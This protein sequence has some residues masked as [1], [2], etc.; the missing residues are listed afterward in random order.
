MRGLHVCAPRFHWSPGRKRR[1]IRR[2]TRAGRE[3][4]DPTIMQVC[5]ILVADARG[6]HWYDDQAAIRAGAPRDGFVYV[7]AT[8]TPGFPQIR[9][10]A[11]AA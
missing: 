10:P 4:E 1:P 3:R 6:A 2:A 7:G 11:R 5:D 8:L 9:M